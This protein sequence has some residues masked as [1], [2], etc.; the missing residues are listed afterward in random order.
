MT[1]DGTQFDG[2]GRAQIVVTL[3]GTQF[4]GNGRAWVTNLYMP[5]K[6]LQPKKIGHNKPQE[7]NKQRIL[8][9]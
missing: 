3:D 2:K 5:N 9:N 6:G 1:L 7:C 8:D 4:D